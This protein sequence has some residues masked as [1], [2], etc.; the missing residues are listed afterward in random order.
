MLSPERI[1]PRRT[2]P[3]TNSLTKV[4]PQRY[5]SSMSESGR[6]LELLT[7]LARVPKAEVDAEEKREQRNKDRRKT[8]KPAAKHGQIVPVKVG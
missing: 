3:P 6:F 7:K 2:R 4:S 1:L 5:N 8:P